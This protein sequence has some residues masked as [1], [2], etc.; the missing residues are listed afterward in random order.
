MNLPPE[1]GTLF[2]NSDNDG[3]YINTGCRLR[4][5]DGY[6]VVTACGLT[7]A[8]YASD[9]AMGRAHAMVLLVSQGLARQTEVAAAFGCNVR[10]VRRQ[11]RRFETEGL[12]ALGR[13]C[14]YPKGK[15]RVPQ[16]QVNKVQRWK[17][18]GISN[19]EIARRL[20][21]NEKAV[22]N[23]AR[24]L[25]W[26]Q[27]APEQ[28]DLPFLTADPNLS[29]PQDAPR[30]DDATAS[31]TSASEQQ[32]ASDLPSTKVVPAD[33]NLSASQ[34][35]EIDRLPLSFDA[36][37]SDR[38]VDRIMACLG[39]LDDAAPMF[40][41]GTRVVGAG[42]LLAIPALL[43]SGVLGIAREIY[44]S[45]GPAFYGL[46]TTV[47]TLLL[48]ALLRIKRPEGLKEH[49]P[50]QMGRLLGLDRAPEVKTLRRKLSRMAM[51][52]RAAS[53]GRALAHNRV[54]QRGHVM[55]FL[56]VDG[57][58]RAYHGK[59]KVPKTHVARIRLAMRA[60]TDYWVN[61]AQGEPLFVIP[62]EAN[63]GLVKA[64]PNMLDEVRKLIGDK[65]VTVVFDRGGWSP[66]LFQKMVSEG[67][68]VL[69]YR[70]GRWRKVPKKQFVSCEMIIE[71]QR[72]CYQLNDRNVLLLK[73]K[74]SMR[75][76]T[77]LSDNGHQTPII[78]SRRDLPAI[79][80]ARRMFGRWRQENFFKYLRQEYALDALVDYGVEQADETRMV[81]NPARKKLDA[82][83]H[84]ATV[85]FEQLA[86]EYG[87][88]V[89]DNHEKKRR[90]IR[91]FKIANSDLGK[92]VR[93]A[94]KLISKLES[95]RAKAPAKIPVAQAVQ[96]DVIKMAVERKH[97]TD[98][99]K[100]VAY[101]AESDL[102]RL[103]APHYKRNEDEGRTLIQ[104]IMTTPGDIE[105]NG[106]ELRVALDPL[107]S[108]HRTR[109]LAKLC[110]DLNCT[111]TR[112]PGS[113]LRLHFGVKPEPSATIAFPGSRD[114]KQ[115]LAAPEPDISAE[116]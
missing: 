1:Q 62:T 70:K 45:V 33:S 17:A 52:G 40:R 28:A 47:L 54:E 55:G 27:Q 5:S 29:A 112:F 68:D 8:H 6:F 38:S 114:V 21:I 66:K 18:E 9:D 95:R 108:P 7:L 61:D 84:K 59:R 63:K 36:D 67:F 98:L 39:L 111:N 41:S 86:A 35:N 16:S 103:V 94:L 74:L 60:S 87:L 64:L 80:V 105:V 96:G 19:R 90:T 15:P 88:E 48:M 49:S 34:K 78:T 81:P 11:L 72:I 13:P 71:G 76:V 2:D 113:K 116:G 73:R 91:G 56:Y 53:F 69:T 79:D 50:A 37:A 106:T 57:H 104:N 102:V 51:H 43:D 109:A 26:R 12:A 93:D 25:G 83:L 89:F 115:R 14:G 75:Q 100:M 10:T 23:L 32:N 44:G 107:S 46:R 24:R 31:L 4:H 82:A 99:L 110:D 92:Q 3:T 77:R 97:L 101:Q 30:V 85:Q 58:V 22:R 42:V 20:G 65:R